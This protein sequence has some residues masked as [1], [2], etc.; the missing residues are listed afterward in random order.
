[1]IKWTEKQ[2]ELN[3]LK[4][5]IYNPRKMIKKAKDVF[6]NNQNKFGEAEPI[7]ANLDGTIISGH[8]RYNIYQQEG[9]KI[10]SVMFPNRQLDK[11]EETELNIKLNSVTGFTD[12]SK[13]FDLGL[14]VDELDGVGFDEISLPKDKKADGSYAEKGKLKNALV[15]N[16][17]YF[18]DDF[19]FVQSVISKIRKQHGLSQAEAIYKL[20][21]DF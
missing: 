4:P 18:P 3:S 10:V 8:M 17:Y 12:A 15:Y 14:S 19:S 5:A 7:V 6:V 20:I 21:K 9:R 1:M 11:K 16:L 2:V 13:I